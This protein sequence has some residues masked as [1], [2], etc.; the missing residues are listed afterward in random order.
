MPKKK[1]LFVSGGVLLLLLVIGTLA[2]LRKPKEI[3]KTP[4]GSPVT[5]QVKFTYQGYLAPRKMEFLQYPEYLKDGEDITLKWEYDQ[6]FAPFAKDVTVA[7]CLMGFNEKN[8]I[9]NKKISDSG[10][11]SYRFYWG[12]G[13]YQI[14]AASLQAKT[15]TFKIKK[16]LAELFSQ[17]PSFYAMQLIVLDNSTGANPSELGGLIGYVESGKIFFAN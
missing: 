12:N 1:I 17:Q 10:P 15:H 2:L 4:D 8:E 16:P 11:C 3:K 7:I 14:G 6:A 9:I 5:Q 13:G